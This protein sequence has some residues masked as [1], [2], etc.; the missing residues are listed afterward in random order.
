MNNILT[1]AFGVLT[2]VVMKYSVSWGIKDSID[3]M[4][5]QITDV[6]FISNESKRQ[7]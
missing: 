4:A 5:L 6:E 1:A 3:Y 2:E 7:G